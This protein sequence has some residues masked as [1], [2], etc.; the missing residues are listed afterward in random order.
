MNAKTLKAL[1]GSIKKWEKILDG[2]AIDEG[3]GNCPL[4]QL[5]WNEIRPCNT[6][7]NKERCPVKIRSGRVGCNRTPYSTWTQHQ[8]NVHGVYWTDKRIK[9]DK[10]K[11]IVKKELDFLKSLL[12]EDSK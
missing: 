4:C 11:P 5:F 9:C 7:D 1:K 12:P 8:L 10:C 2:K 6:P 3:R